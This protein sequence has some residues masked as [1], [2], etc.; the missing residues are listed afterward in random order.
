MIKPFPTIIYSQKQPLYDYTDDTEKSLLIIGVEERDEDSTVETSNITD[1]EDQDLVKMFIARDYNQR[2]LYS[3]QP[4]SISSLVQSERI[5]GSDSRVHK[6]ASDIYDI[7]K[8]LRLYGMNIHLSDNEINRKIDVMNFIE[9][10]EHMDVDYILMDSKVRIENDSF[11]FEKFL[12]LANLKEN[13]GSLVHMFTLTML[14]EANKDTVFDK[15]EEMKRVSRGKTVEMGKYVSI[16]NNQLT[17]IEA[18]T[19]YASLLLT[20]EIQESPVNKKLIENVVLNNEISLS[21]EKEYYENGVVILKD[22]F[23]RGVIFGNST[24]AVTGTESEHKS[25]ENFKIVNAIIKTLK[26][27][28]NALIGIG[29]RHMFFNQ[30]IMSV[31]SE[32]ESEYIKRGAIKEMDYEFTISDSVGIVFL[33]LYIVPIFSIKEIEVSTRI[34]V[35]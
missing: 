34:E 3:Y 32:T 23:H 18:H 9:T 30:Y 14:N 6:M 29:E 27:K 11:L 26:G 10:L 8:P 16:I 17:G 25:F 13:Q 7:T 28:L 33:K 4:Y 22:S 19:Y 21:D 5:F 12:D 35:N 31:L 2:E 1:F 15:I 20:Q 24:T